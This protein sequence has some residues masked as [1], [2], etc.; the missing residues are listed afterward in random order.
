MIMM[1]VFVTFLLLFS[2]EILIAFFAAAES[3]A[4][5]FRLHLVLLFSLVVLIAFFAQTN[6]LIAAVSMLTLVTRVM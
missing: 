4:S 5:G 3:F 6:S 1:P 2:L